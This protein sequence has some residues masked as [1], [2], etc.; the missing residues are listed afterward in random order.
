MPGARVDPEYLLGLAGVLA[1]LRARARDGAEE[2]LGHFTVLGD[3]E[4]Q[5]A[6]D[7]LLEQAADTLRALDQEAT[8]QA[9]RL[10]ETAR[11]ADHAERG[12][13]TLMDGPAGRVGATGAA[14]HRGSD[15]G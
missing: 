3:R 14:R 9:L 7:A 1:P 2:L 11:R 13:H 15:A 8:E 6:V 4:T 10:Q 5:R 12:V